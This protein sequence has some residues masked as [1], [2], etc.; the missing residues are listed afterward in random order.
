MIY[1]NLLAD[2][3]GEPELSNFAE[4]FFKAAGVSS[5]EERESSNYLG[6]QYFKGDEGEM[7]WTVSRSDEDYPDLPY[8][9]SVATEQTDPDELI[10]GMNDLIRTKLLPLGFRVARLANFGRKNQERIDY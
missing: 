9:I 6:G 10:A 3:P 8:W 5:V 2:L 4:R 1:I 7:T